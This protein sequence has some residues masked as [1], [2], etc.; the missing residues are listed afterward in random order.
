MDNQPSFQIRIIASLDEV[1]A[2][3]WDRLAGSTDDTCDNPFI[4]HA[5]LSALEKSGSACMETGWLPQHLLLEDDSGNVLGAMPCYLK[6]HSQG[7]YVFD[8]GWADAFQR[9]G[10]E[11]YPKLQCSIPFTPATGP[12]FL[13]G[14]AANADQ[15]QTALMQGL[16]Q[17]AVKIGAS[18]VHI[19]FMREHEWRQ[20]GETNY[21]QREDRQFHWQNDDYKGFEDFLLSLASR[22]RKNIRKE[23]E[24]AQNIKGLE[25]VSLTG[26]D[27]TE[28]AWDAFYR[29]Y[30]D[31]GSRKWGRPY[32]TRDFFSIIGKTIADKVL[33]IMAKRDGKFVAGAI[34]FIGSD[35]LY[36]R[37]WGC[38]ENHPFLHFEICYYQAIDY[39]IEKG[40]SRVEA[41][42]QGEHK[43]ARGYVP[44][45]TFSAHWI[46]HPGLSDAIENYLEHE[47]EHVKMEND[48]LAEHKPFKKVDR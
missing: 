43:L 34:N 42:A 26:E 36:G 5:F 30:M 41:G 13:T 16:Q 21:L 18:S 4:S 7:E 3:V 33:L 40:L 46:A 39:A 8:H 27:L 44:S 11:Y 37:H 9:A 6:N 35:C 12:R 31:T 47:R 38:E 24:A 10:G 32:L 23:R 28:E 45:S 1:D 14:N 15:I 29:F 17:L 48:I 20:A 19:T 22:K 25:V 2:N